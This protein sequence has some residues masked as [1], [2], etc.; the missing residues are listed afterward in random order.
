MDYRSATRDWRHTIV[1][2][3]FSLPGVSFQSWIII[4]FTNQLHV[5]FFTRIKNRM[6][7]MT[8]TPVYL[9]DM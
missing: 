7:E 5:D 8:S 1:A 4:L 6:S 3:K 2:V 9:V